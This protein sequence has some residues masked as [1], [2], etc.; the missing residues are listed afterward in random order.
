M[1]AELL[2]QSESE[3]GLIRSSRIAEWLQKWRS[4]VHHP[5]PTQAVCRRIVAA[6]RHCVVTL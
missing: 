3:M 2:A 6:A 5:T 4:H 1:L